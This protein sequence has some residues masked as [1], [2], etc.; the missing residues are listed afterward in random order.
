MSFGLSKTIRMMT[1]ALALLAANSV[2]AGGPVD[3]TPLEN[4]NL[5]GENILADFY[6]FESKSKQTFKMAEDNINRI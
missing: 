1:T 6:I 2:F 3:C 5:D 4:F